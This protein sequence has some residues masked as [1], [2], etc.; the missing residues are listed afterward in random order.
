MSMKWWREELDPLIHGYTY[1]CQMS[2]YC[3]IDVEDIYTLLSTW[4][5]TPAKKGGSSRTQ[6]SQWGMHC[7]RLSFLDLVLESRECDR[8]YEGKRDHTDVAKPDDRVCTVSHPASGQGVILSPRVSVTSHVCLWCR[9]TVAWLR[10]P[11][12]SLW[13]RHRHPEAKLRPL[14]QVTSSEGGR[15]GQLSITS[16]S[17]VLV[18]VRGK[19]M[20]DGWRRGSM[21]WWRMTITCD[22]SISCVLIFFL[23]LSQIDNNDDFFFNF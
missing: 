9:L 11:D 4:G 5:V 23:V 22:C 6:K 14:E 2:R 20:G 17:P 7:K 10:P 21:D 15:P 16:F 1:S 13:S 19:R 18:G 3:Q 12:E 8:W